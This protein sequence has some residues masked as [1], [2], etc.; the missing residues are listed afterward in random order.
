MMKRSP[1]LRR[2]TDPETVAVEINGYSVPV[3][4]GDEEREKESR[5]R[6]TLCDVTALSRA[7][8][9][10][11]NISSWLQAQH[12]IELPSVN[13]AL[14][15]EL[16]LMV[17]RLSQTEI[18][19]SQD[20]EERGEGFNQMLDKSGC[21]PISE[22][23]PDIYYLPRQ[24]S[25]SC[26]MLSGEHCATMFSKLCAVDLR[27]NKFPNM[28][29]AQTSLARASV[30]I[31]RRDLSETPAYFILMDSSLT[32][33]LWDCLLDAM[34]EYDGKIIGCSNFGFFSTSSWHV[35]N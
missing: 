7:G 23:H 30:I 35:Y 19:V 22:S 16:G 10:G 33:Y 4:V 29:V 21:D 34:Q 2:F 26:F 11:K 27:V 31:I 8:F 18:L 17:T 28:S 3:S 13:Q 5:T 15:T 32:E 25:H 14:I 12:N 24:D 9:R 1:I 20:I 6:L